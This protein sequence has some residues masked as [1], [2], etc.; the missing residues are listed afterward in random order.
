VLLSAL[1]W[2]V[3]GYA[4]SSWVYAAAGSMP[5]RQAQVQTLAFPLALPVI[6]AYFMATTTLACARSASRGWRWPSTGG[7]SSGSGHGSGSVTSCPFASSLGRAA[8]QLVLEGR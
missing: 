2:L 6:F 4:F 3:L 7:R 8:D 1:I 5:E